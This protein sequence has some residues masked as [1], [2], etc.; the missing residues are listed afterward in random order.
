MFLMFI[1]YKFGLNLYE[2]G[3]VS[4]IRDKT[5]AEL[6]IDTGR[7]AEAAGFLALAFI[8]QP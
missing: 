2:N 6:K 4:N 1:I 5:G 8:N 3:S 7:Y